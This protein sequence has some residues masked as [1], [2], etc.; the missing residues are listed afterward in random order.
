[1]TGSARGLFAATGND[2]KP[3]TVTTGEDLAGA[4]ERAEFNERQKDEFY[5]TPPEPTVAL[6]LAERDRLRDFPLIWEP[7]C[8]DGAMVRD[9]NALG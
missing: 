8:G 9:L 5:P 7:A 2:A 4:F 6:V 1:M 3:I